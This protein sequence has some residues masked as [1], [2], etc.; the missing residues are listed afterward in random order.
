VKTDDLVTLLRAVV[1]DEL[2]CPIT[3][4]GMAKAGLL[5][6]GDDIGHLHGLDRA[7]VRAVLV[8]V[9]AERRR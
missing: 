8:A 1:R 5:R 9:I 2:T 7:G 6:L 4:L 3:S